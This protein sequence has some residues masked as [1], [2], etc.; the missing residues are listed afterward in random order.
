[1]MKEWF[2]KAKLGIF[3]HWGVYA[4]KGISESWSFGLGEISYDDYMS[5]LKGFT[6]SKYDPKAWAKLF[7]Q[8]GAN[9]VVLTTKHHDGVALFDTKYTDLNVVK[10]S[11]A[12]RDLVAPYCEALREEGIKVGLYFTNTDWSDFDHFNVILDKTKEE[13]LELHKEKTSYRLLWDKVRNEEMNMKEEDLNITTEKEEAWSRFM[14]RYKGEITELLTNYGNVDLLWFDVM[15]TRRGYSWDSKNVK[16]MIN[17]LNP[18]TVVNSR[19]GDY[20][21]YET[22]EMYIPLTP[23]DKPWELCSTLTDAWGFRAEDNNYKDV[24]QVVRML[25]ECISKG[26]NL[27]LSIG[28]DAEGKIPLESEEKLLQLGEWTNKYYEAIYPT[29]KGIGPEYF[30]GGTTLTE[31]KKTLYLFVYDR[32]Y[33]KIMLNGIRTKIKKITSMVSGTELTY[34]II[35]GASWLNMPGCIWIDIDEKDLDEVCTVVKVEFEDVID[36]VEV[37]KETK[38]AGE[39]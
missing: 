19:L 5:Q 20:G 6:A 16:E 3:I 1:M 29:E 27:L 13:L 37:N 38:S 9:Y 10:K 12:G 7:K 31:D 14:D 2:R 32:P 24:R 21:D 36:L 11:P 15:I 28:P 4:V 8:A 39:M 18:N 30:L 26:G 35:G 17:T 25:C 34:R 23:I 22:P 33:N